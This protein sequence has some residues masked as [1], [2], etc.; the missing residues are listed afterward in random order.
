MYHQAELQSHSV[1][2]LAGWPRRR[3]GRLGCGATIGPW[4]NRSSIRPLSRDAT[5]RRSMYQRAELQ[6]H[7]V[8]VLTKPARIGFIRAHG[9]PFFVGLRDRA[10]LMRKGPPAR[11]DRFLKTEPRLSP[12]TSGLSSQR[13]IFAGTA[14][15]GKSRRQRQRNLGGKQ[16]RAATGERRQRRSFDPTPPISKSACIWGRNGQSLCPP[17]CWFPTPSKRSPQWLGSTTQPPPPTA[18][19][20]HAV[21]SGITGHQMLTPSFSFSD[22]A[23]SQ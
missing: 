7:S 15:Q 19:A 18:N 9:L 2:V 3:F 20:D 16:H 11:R 22:P 8:A 6:R 13:L 14:R 12:G 10:D 4:R 17:A 5:V 23:R 21:N 1:A